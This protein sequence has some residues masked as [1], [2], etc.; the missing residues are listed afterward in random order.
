MQIYQ[1]E[2]GVT[3]DYATKELAKYIE[4]MCG[5]RVEFRYQ[6]G[7]NGIVLGLFETLN[8]SF[9][10][11]ENAELDDAY[12]VKVDGFRGYI[13]GSNI[14]S[15]LYGVYAYL[16]AA[17]CRF[18]RP[19]KDG[20][21]VPTVNLSTFK[22]DFRIKA[23]HRCRW[24]CIE[25]A[26]SY[27]FVRDYVE[28]LPKIGF[29]G[30]MLQATSPYL[31]YAK[32]YEHHGNPNKPVEPLSTEEADIITD[33]L[34][35]DI[36]R[37]GLTLHSVGHD[38]MSPAFG[39]FGNGITEQE[40][41]Q[42]GMRDYLAL[43]NGE[44]KIMRGHFRYTN[45]CFSNPTVRRKLA[46]YFVK[47]VTEKPEVD[48]L[49]IWRADSSNTNC[50]CEEC[51]KGTVSDQYIKVLNDVDEA[52]SAKGIK[53]KI[54]FV[55]SRDGCWLPL[56]E[57]FKNND[58]F[59]FMCPV[60]QDYISG[61]TNWKK[62]V[63]LPTFELNKNNLSMSDFVMNMSFFKEWK[64]IFD[65]NSF[66][67]EYHLYSDHYCDP[68]Y[69][70]ISERLMRDL[71]LLD[72]I[73]VNG[74]MH[75][76]SPRKS[77]P[78]SY[79]MYMSGRILM[80]PTLGEEE[81]SEEYYSAA[82]GKDWRKVYTYL[83][84]LSDLFQPDLIRNTAVGAADE[85]FTDYVKIVLPYMNNP[86]ALKDFSKIGGVISDFEAVIAENIEN[87]NACIRKSWD[88]L[89]VHAQIARQIAEGLCAGAAGDMATAQNICRSLVRYLR[90]IEDDY[91]YEFDFLLLYR[92]LKV[93]FGFTSTVYSS[94]KNDI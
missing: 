63:E 6:L 27:E 92:R 67:F 39:L 45:L 72:D 9:E 19:G 59:I 76:S 23:H 8:L 50:E 94:V 68:G 57:K 83:H 22:A 25:G 82:F 24:D 75:C 12:E 73:G 61:Y 5:E 38:Y 30:Y 60:R 42:K 55:M 69:S 44:R 53:T 88:I 29:N 52:F 65:G 47:Y 80:D 78:T 66:F 62:S 49:H 85:M 58:R 17:G 43:V 15:I 46:D 1:L 16:K 26:V 51:R 74:Y 11:I 3:A 31:W 77:M 71:K 33:K 28:W 91:V 89:R 79:P 81:I 54:V 86:E 35:A 21:I 84:T 18:V 7:E 90:E 56:S 10:G 2:T 64:K 36:N 87:R 34:E 32:W 4:K 13:A 41:D 37:C 70:Q 14:R 40:V 48:Y 20:E 93:M